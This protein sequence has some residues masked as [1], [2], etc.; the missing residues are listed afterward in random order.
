MRQNSWRLDRAT[1]TGFVLAASSDGN[2]PLVRHG[3]SSNFVG[4]RLG[5]DLAK[6]SIDFV[7]K[8]TVLT[9]HGELA[10]VEQGH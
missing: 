10:A 4:N 7:A 2:L 1:S 8:C 9:Y 5:N 3:D 6:E